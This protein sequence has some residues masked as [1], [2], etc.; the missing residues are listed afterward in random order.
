MAGL[1]AKQLVIRG[2]AADQEKLNW[3]SQY[4]DV[5]ELAMPMRNLY[6]TYTKGADKMTRVYNS[7]AIISTQKFASRLQANLTPPYQQWL[8][9]VP[10]VEIPDENREEAM[11]ELQQVRK[12]FFSVIENSNFDTVITE[13]YLDLAAGTGCM[14]VQEGDDD[15]PV[16]FTAVPNAQISMDE[17]PMSEVDGVFR[18]H[19]IAVRNI[20]ATWPDILPGGKAKIAELIKSQGE[21]S[22]AQKVNVLEA[23][24]QDLKTKKWY[25]QVVLK[26]TQD[27]S[28]ISQSTPTQSLDSSSA[29]LLVERVLTDTPWIIT[30][31]IKLAGETFG[32]GPLLFALPDIKTLNKT[33]ELML[34]NASMAI[35]GLWA[36]QSDSISNLNMVKLSAGTFLPMDRIEDIERLDVPGDLG[37]G[38]AISEKLENSIRAALFDRSLPDPTGAVR[39]PTEIIERVRE[40]AQDIGAPFS[41]I[42]SEMLQRVATRVL[43]IMDKR[44]MLDFPIKVDG[45]AVKVIPTSP[46]AREQNLNDL[47]SAVQWLTIV[48]GIGPEV[49][50]GTVRVED[51]AEWSAE[52]LGVDLKLVKSDG[53]RSEMK[54]MV[55]QLLAAAQQEAQ[56]G[57]TQPQAA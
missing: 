37:I 15:N 30:R 11:L 7:T 31:W 36:V 16:R 3:V 21:K 19:T 5:Y 50:L 8:D 54:D 9:F 34:Q 1:S 12:R 24:Y 2:N 32:R 47:E 56:A 25:Y 41:R 42:N 43:G 46:L 6:T 39:S 23:T 45:K 20:E 13:F 52:K 28:E 29:V 40:L 48:Q 10:G 35:G 57:Q 53:E 49:M 17:G 26:G 38:E 4:R 14:L 44:G 22:D 27:N 55:A 51:F 18:Q 33:T